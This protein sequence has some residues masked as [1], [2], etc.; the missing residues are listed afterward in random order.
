MA[1][2]RPRIE[3]IRRANEQ[4]A[5]SEAVVGRPRRRA[6]DQVRQGAPWRSPPQRH[7][8]LDFEAS[9]LEADKPTRNR[10]CAIDKPRVPG[11]RSGADFHSTKCTQGRRRDIRNSCRHHCLACPQ[12]AALSVAA[13]DAHRRRTRVSPVVSSRSA[14]NVRRGRPRGFPGEKQSEVS[15]RS[16]SRGC[17]EIRRS[18]RWPSRDPTHRGAGRLAHDH[19]SIRIVPHS[20]RAG[21]DARPPPAARERL[22]CRACTRPMREVE[23]SRTTAA[24]AIATMASAIGST[25][26]ER[27]DSGRGC[28]T[29]SAERRQ[30]PRSRR[31]TDRRLGE[32][33]LIHSG[34]ES[35]EDYCGPA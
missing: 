4:S 2:H 30:R 1:G 19:R 23:D 8:A 9:S 35:W 33:P 10:R 7:P 22:C 32:S 29:R 28:R 3:S 17:A 27:P 25:T 16:R 18:R 20:T 5:G 6:E 21:T 26:R 15:L 24:R 11:E 34:R 12:A 14:C 31:S 13:R